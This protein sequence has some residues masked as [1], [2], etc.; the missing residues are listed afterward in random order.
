MAP[1]RS[2][3]PLGKQLE[4]YEESWKTDH[5]E[6]K[7]TLWRF[8]DML[9]VGLALFK[10]IHD[11][12]WAWCDRVRRGTKEYDPAEEQEFKERFAGWLR[13]CDQILRRLEHLEAQYGAVE[14]GPRFRQFYQ[15]AS[16]ILERWTPPRPATETTRAPAHTGRAL[17]V[18]QMADALDRVS[19][20]AAE[21]SV[22]LQHPIDETKAF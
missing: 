1:T 18:Q 3:D 6:V 13:P 19:R 21:G 12:Y 20:P 9:A 7:R 4:V 8:E 10:A 14:G 11:R 2:T 15:E 16:Q 5:E 17:T 22:P